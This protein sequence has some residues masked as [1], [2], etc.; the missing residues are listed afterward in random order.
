MIKR[1]LFLIGVIYLLRALTS[2]VSVSEAVRGYR[3]YIAD[4]P[5]VRSSVPEEQKED[6]T[7]GD[8]WKDQLR[9]IHNR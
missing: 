8:P 2:F 7:T 1:S 5:V 3:S 9:D 4:L 6:M